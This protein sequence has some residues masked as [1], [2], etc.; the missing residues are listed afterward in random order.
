MD[1]KVFVPRLTSAFNGPCQRR[2]V[3]VFGRVPRTPSHRPSSQCAVFDYRTLRWGPLP[4]VHSPVASKR[5]GRHVHTRTP[6]G[7]PSVLRRGFPAARQH[8]TR[9]PSNAF[10]LQLQLR[11]L[12]LPALRTTAQRTGT[13]PPIPRRDSSLVVAGLSHDAHRRLPPP[14]GATHP[15]CGSHPMA[16]CGAIMPV[17]WTIPATTGR[18]PRMPC[19]W[20]EFRVSDC[21]RPS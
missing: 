17:A 19:V 10:R 1:A 20:L 13:A 3:R 4:Q 16:L 12:L 21:R 11:T 5:A 15:R 18:A 7:S 9:N 2:I 14:A 8:R 6:R